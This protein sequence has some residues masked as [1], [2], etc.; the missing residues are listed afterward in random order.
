MVR[1]F[2]LDPEVRFERRWARSV[3][4]CTGL[5]VCCANLARRTNGRKLTNSAR[6]A[7]HCLA[8]ALTH[9]VAI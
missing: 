2:L 5:N 1:R 6:D 7:L 4:I 3:P 9:R 8:D